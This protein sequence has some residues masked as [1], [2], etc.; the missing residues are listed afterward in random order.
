MS[1]NIFLLAIAA[2]LLVFVWLLWLRSRLLHDLK[3][4]NDRLKILQKD[5][6]KRRDTVPFLLEAVRM[7]KGTDDLWNKL[8]DERARFHEKADM[9]MEM[10]IE[11]TLQTYLEHLEKIQDLHFLE[12]KKDVQDLGKIIEQEKT[13]VAEAAAS[14]NDRRKQFPYS[15]VSAIFGLRKVSP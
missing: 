12:A 1:S 10:E 8:V 15:L 13:N 5:F 3:T 14:Y 4:F 7:Q 11:K 9:K 2:L 6:Q